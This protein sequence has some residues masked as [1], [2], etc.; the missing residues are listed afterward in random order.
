MEYQ[1]DKRPEMHYHSTIRK[2]PETVRPTNWHIITGAP[3][4]GKTTVIKELER[5]GFR[6][7]HEVARAYID[8]QLARGLE[9]D[10]I[11]ADILQFE[12][13]IL[14]TKIRIEDSLRGIEPVFFDRGVPD[15]IAY[16]NLEGL[17]PSEP[18]KHSRMTR[19]RRIFFFERFDFLND[20]VRSEDETIAAKLN[21]LLLEA[22]A[23]IG[24]DIIMVPVMPVEDRTDLVLRVIK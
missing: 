9:L 16:F 17:D 22:Y 12:R 11:K 18:L 7:I 8:R 20:E 14:H 24:S 21:D 3:C 4:S 15:S 1:K 6:V 23:M 13:H 2:E 10:R 5:R 19:Y